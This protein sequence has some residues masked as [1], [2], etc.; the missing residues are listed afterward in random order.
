[1]TN[2]LRPDADEDPVSSPSKKLAASL[3][4][5]AAIALIG[6]VSVTGATGAAGKRA[7]APAQASV[8]NGKLATPGQ[9]PWMAFIVAVEGELVFACSGSVIAPRVV[10]TAAHCTL[11]EESHA[12]YD[13]AGY[14]VVT[15]AVNWADPNGRQTSKVTQLIPYPKYAAKTSR[16]EFGDAA[17]LVLE[18]P[19]TVPGIALAKRSDRRYLRLGTRARLAGW[20]QTHDEQAEFTESLYWTKTVVESDR[21]ER[22][23][24]AICAV[25]FPKFKSGGCFGDSGGPLF[26]GRR[27]QGWLEIGIVH[28]GFDHCTTRRPA[29][30]TRVDLLRKWIM[31]RVRKIESEAAAVPAG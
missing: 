7:A 28:G 4:A 10:L 18:T 20:G 6:I 26:V 11:D 21:C 19:T 13:P 23:W 22:L 27:E 16:D 2:L 15:G 31:G 5:I 14:T 3:A 12:P 1:V 17:L 24:G 8:I 29:I 25:D 30:Y 9:Y